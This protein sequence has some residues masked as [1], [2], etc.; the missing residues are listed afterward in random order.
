MSAFCGCQV[1][2]TEKRSCQGSGIFVVPT[3]ILE[4]TNS[5]GISLLLWTLGAVVAI[6]GLLVWLELALT[7]PQVEVGTGQKVSVSRSGGEKNYVSICNST[8]IR[9]SPNSAQLEYIYD[10]PRFLATCIFAV[11]FIIFS[12]ASSNAVAFAVYIMRAAG[13]PDD[14]AATRGVAIA[15]ITAACLIHVSWR[16]GGIL[17]NNAITIIKVA[18]LLSIIVLGF[19]TRGGAS[20]GHGRIQ[21]TNFDIHTSFANPRGATATYANS[22]IFI[23]GAY[24]GFRQPFYVSIPR[25]LSLSL[26]GQGADFG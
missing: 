10:R 7:I 19:A 23:I 1:I 18:I 26:R 14:A 6:S 2:G 13:L 12:N 5:V 20:F 3:I 11:D 4:N 16:K 9:A 22:F 17:L 24:N 21:T 25:V 8:H 15:A